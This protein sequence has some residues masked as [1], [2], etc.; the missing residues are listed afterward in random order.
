[1]TTVINPIH[2]V[3]S[4][5]DKNGRFLVNPDYHFGAPPKEVRPDVEHY[6][7][8]VIKGNAR[9][10][11]PVGDPGSSPKVFFKT[12][13]G[14]KYMTLP[15]H[16]GVHPRTAPYMRYPVQGWS[17]MTTQALYHA[18][19]I[20]HLV[21]Q[22][23]VA[24]HKDHKGKEWPMLVV[25]LD[26]NAT[27]SIASM[28]GYQGAYP[29]QMYDDA[30]KIGMMDFLTNQNDRHEGNLL[31]HPS[32]TTAPHRILAI[33]NRRAFQY[34]VP[35]RFQHINDTRDHLFYYIGDNRGF[36]PLTHLSGSDFRKV[37]STP[38]AEEGVQ[39]WRGA[40]ANIRKEF[41]IQL[42]SIQHPGV[43]DYMQQNFNERADM[44]DHFA[45]AWNKKSNADEYDPYIEGNK[46]AE[47]LYIKMHPF[48]GRKAV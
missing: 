23:H 21:Q 22:S 46:G 45:K 37:W 10:I 11:K 4:S 6:H 39:W 34:K 33:D 24:F 16:E 8:N 17:E 19:G 31:F 25:K 26:Q 43:R 32:K 1:M 15:Y 13:D 36:D 7:S 41:E 38:H 28:R 18:G 9:T 5:S 48:Y 27:H 2:H 44:L 12:D 3:I 42:R 29:H 35:N 30:F 40:G 20:G 47:K 14:A